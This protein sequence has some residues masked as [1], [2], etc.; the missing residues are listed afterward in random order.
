LMLLLLSPWSVL[1][2]GWYASFRAPF[3]F[4]W[5]F[6]ASNFDVCFWCCRLHWQSRPFSI[7]D[8]VLSLYI[9]EEWRR[10]GLASFL[11]QTVPSSRGSS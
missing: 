7:A 1:L 11:M 5:W 3:L 8:A 4:F 2:M 10:E 9:G 6:D